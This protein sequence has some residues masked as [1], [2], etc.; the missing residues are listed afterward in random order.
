MIL[1]KTQYK[2]AMKDNF[3]YVLENDF[4]EEGI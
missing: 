2:N 3:G 1:I 4:A